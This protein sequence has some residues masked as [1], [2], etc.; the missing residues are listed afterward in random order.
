MEKVFR[1]AKVTAIA[2]STFGLV[3]FVLLIP[4]VMASLR[5]L[6]MVEFE[7]WVMTMH[8]W[9]F[10]MAAIV[11]LVT[12]M[13]EVRAIW[14]EMKRRKVYGNRVYDHVGVDSKSGHAFVNNGLAGN[15]AATASINVAV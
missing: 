3:L 13:E 14:R 6:S 4:G 12:P 1:K 15:E 10:V 8:I 9:C 5:V 2:G 11:I 7:A